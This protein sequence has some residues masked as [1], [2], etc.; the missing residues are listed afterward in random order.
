MYAIEVTTAAEQE[1][2]TLEEAKAQTKF[3]DDTDD[4]RLRRLIA[5]AREAVEAATHRRLMNQ[6]LKMYIDWGWPTADGYRRIDFPVNP[7]RSVDSITYID[8]DG[9]SQTLAADQYTVAGRRHNS[10]IVPAYGVEWPTA[11]N[12]PNAVTVT[13]QAGNSDDVP[14]LARHAIAMLLT[15][16]FENVGDDGSIDTQ[17]YPPSFEALVSPLRGRIARG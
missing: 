2:L 12:V 14:E 17:Q 11:R 15:F 5:T 10:F 3:D 1:P 9:A 16:W 8:S 6:T 7:V 4:A 13:F